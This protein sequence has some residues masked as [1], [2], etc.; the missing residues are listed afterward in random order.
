MS[1]KIKKVLNALPMLSLFAWGAVT[2]F[3]TSEEKGEIIASQ[4]KES[5]IN[6]ALGQMMTGT[7]GE[8]APSDVEAPPPI[9]AEDFRRGFVLTQTLTNEVHDFS[10][11]DGAIVCEKWRKRGANEDAFVLAATD[12]TPWMFPVGTSVFSRVRVYSSGVVKPIGADGVIEVFKANLGI[13]PQANWETPLSSL[14]WHYL[15]SSNSLQLTWQNVLFEREA[16]QPISF[17]VEFFENGDFTCRY[18]LSSIS[19]LFPVSSSPFPSSLVFRRLNPADAPGGD[20]DGDG[21]SVED[22]LFIHNTDPY[23]RDSDYDGLGD[24]EELFVCNTDPCNPHT[25]SDIYSDAFAA[26]LGNLDPFSFPVGST[27][28]VLEHI[29]Y[30]GTTNGA[31]AYPQSSDSTAVLKISVIGSGSG[32]LI[33]G[34]CVVPLLP[35]PLIARSAPPPSE[36][37][38]ALPKGKTLQLKARGDADVTLDSSNFAFGVLPSG[39]RGGW[40]NFPITKATSPCI[41]DFNARKKA[42]SL[43]TGEDAD[44]LTCTWQSGEKVEAENHPPRS[45]EIT[46]VFNPKD[47]GNLTYTLHHPKYLFGEATYSQAVRFCPKPSESEEGE[48]NPPWYWGGN[49]DEDAEKCWNCELGLCDSWCDC[50]CEGNCGESGD[51]EY[52]DVEFDEICPEHELPYDEC[53]YLHIEDYTNAVASVQHLG[54]VLYL[55]DSPKYEEIH[56]EVP[57]E[58]RNCCDCPDHWTNYVGVAYQSSRLSLV[59]INE[60]PFE[61]TDKSCTVNLAGVSPSSSV[62]DARLAFSRNGEMYLEYEKTVLGV[63]ISAP[64]L[65]KCNALNESFGVP[66]TVCT[67][68]ARGAELN[69]IANVKLPTG[70]IHLELADVSG[71]FSLWYYD[72]EIGDYRK[73]LDSQTMRQKTLPFA[74][75]KEMMK[76]SGSAPNLPVYITSAESGSAKLIFRYWAVID[77]KFVQD[78]AEQRITSVLPLVKM[79]INYDNAINENDIS[80]SL[81]GRVFRFWYNTETVKGDYVGHVENVLPNINDNVVNGKYDLIN[82]F[83]ME[84]DVTSLRAAW[85]DNVTYRLKAENPKAGDFNFCMA[86]VSK[87]NIRSMQTSAVITA[88][89]KELSQADLISI[90]ADGYVFSRAELDALSSGEQ[91]LVVEARQRNN[92][93]VSVELD[94]AEL[95]SYT[96]P[97]SISSIRQ[98]YRWLNERYASGDNGGEP[99]QL[100]S[101]WNRPDEE[102]DGRH[103]VF[104][105]GYNVNAADARVWADQMFKRLWWAGSK[106]MFTAVDWRGDSS[107]FSLMFTDMK[108]SPDYYVN[109]KNAFLTAPVFAQ[110]CNSLPGEKIVLA[111]SLGNMLVSSAAKDYGLNYSKYYM[112]NAAVPMEAYDKSSFIDAMCDEEWSNVPVEY[113][114]SNWSKLFPANDFRSSLSWRGRFEGIA[115]AINCY[116]PTEDVLANA[117]IGQLTFS[118]GAWKIQELTKG[119]TV[120]HELNSISFL[121]LDV[122]CEGGWGINTHYSLNPLWYVYQYGFTEKAKND[123]TREDAIIHPLFTPFRNENEAMHSTNLFTI[124]DTVYREQL[125]AKFLADA[126]PATSFAVGA[127]HTSGVKDNHNMHD[128]MAEGWPRRKNNK[129]IWLHSD[130]KNIA[131]VFLYPLFDNF[132]EEEIKQ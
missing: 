123:L 117:E 96:A 25:L 6:E 42:V 116:S 86:N 59:D 20:F 73:L 52:A 33:V 100:G 114:A 87:S 18:D 31:F 19:S 26:K 82:F 102:C 51:N 4:R 109:V 84:I 110:D 77:G 16:D 53:A 70:N 67:N 13:V 37:L 91:L 72:S 3:P 21:L 74:A 7:G 71:K 9:T 65:E 80:A 2:A 94:G 115:N 130:I 39:N 22:E 50:G 122:A 107:Q 57:S 28:T 85:G 56:L 66:L 23:N 79:D 12:E 15:T 93:V 75:W 126:T 45:A 68:A 36:L 111:H 129:N 60:N 58:Y 55:R 88:N 54:G 108:I 90:P 48:V 128:F 112:L 61:L 119:T 10:V 118:G 35:R 8:G 62:G 32:D 120:W 24:R 124:A 34:E 99:S 5:A 63:A 64:G 69:L 83:P 89:G 105:H 97:L 103:F 40:I 43:P 121:N 76:R 11:P 81:A 127:N 131:Y 44:G 106:S 47:D 92:L 38:L 78:S 125:C 95:Y 17:Q 104:V 101:P 1:P 41:H 49:D 46:G 132:I 98:M 30:S 27:N 14:F 113:F 29:F